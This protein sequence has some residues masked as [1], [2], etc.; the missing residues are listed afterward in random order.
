MDQKLRH[1]ALDRA[2]LIE[3]RVGGVELG[4]EADDAVFE[5]AERELLAA[6]KLVA[7]HAVGEAVE[8]RFDARRQRRAAAGIP[9]LFRER[10]DLL[11]QRR[12]HVGA[13]RTAAPATRSI[14]ADRPRTSS[15][16]APS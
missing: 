4:G 5:R 10:A 3:P 1:A 2:E 16:S 13:A 11:F 9:E 15:A 12:M 14:F 6:G 8:Q 7:L